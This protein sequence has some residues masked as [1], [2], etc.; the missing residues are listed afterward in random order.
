MKK[1]LVP[2]DFSDIGLN[3]LKY[4]LEAFK[5]NKIYV[6]HVRKSLN[7]PFPSLPD[8]EVNQPEFWVS[9]I[10]GFLKKELGKSI[11][12][13]D[14]EISVLQGPLAKTIVEFGEENDVDAIVMGFRDKYNYFEKIFGTTTLDVVKISKI[15]VYLIPKYGRYRGFSKVVVATDNK[16]TNPN[17]ILKIKE[18]NEEDNA[19]IKFLHIKQNGNESFK[20]TANELVTALFI[21]KD[22][23]FSFEIS[24]IDDP[25]I[26]HALLGMSYNMGADLMIISPE[27]QNLL[28]T[29]LLK[30]MSKELI[31]TADIPLLFI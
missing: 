5:E 21:D 24:T 27:R 13:D 11:K 15:P 9:A 25:E 4:A 3:A 16:I 22:P 7:R 12:V 19:F 8:S 26:G 10:E 23:N 29:V 14:L 30:S 2:I 17:L 20:E 28:D 6:L 31:L 1:V 18:L